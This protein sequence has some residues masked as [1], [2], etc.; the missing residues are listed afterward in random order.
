MKK[1]VVKNTVKRTVKKKANA[2]TTTRISTN[3][4]VMPSGV[5]RARKAVDGVKY[6]CNFTNL[7]E[8]RKWINSL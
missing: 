5:Y 3:I 6:S 7:K 1:N 4:G 2:S 8:A